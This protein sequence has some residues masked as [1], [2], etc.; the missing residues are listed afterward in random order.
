MLF[1]TIISIILIFI[2]GAIYIYNDHVSKLPG[3]CSKY[4]DLVRSESGSWNSK[5]LELNSFYTWG[6]RYDETTKKLLKSE[7]VSGY[8]VLVPNGKFVSHRFYQKDNNTKNQ[9]KFNLFEL[10]HKEIISPDSKTTTWWEAYVSAFQLINEFSS[11]DCKN[12]D[13]AEWLKL[14]EFFEIFPMS[15]TPGFQ[16]MEILLD[17]EAKVILAISYIEDKGEGFYDGLVMSLKGDSVIHLTIS[18]K[19][20]YSVIASLVET[21]IVMKQQKIGTN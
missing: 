16:N 18:N 9:K 3:F 11:F 6:D 10:L 7:E 14:T 4:I 2:G 19:D 21:A 20:K 5:A 15:L 13:Y 12:L 8:E 17:D 1:R